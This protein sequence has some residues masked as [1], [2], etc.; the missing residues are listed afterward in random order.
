MSKPGETKA[1]RISDYFTTKSPTREHLVKPPSQQKK[2]AVERRGISGSKKDMNTSAKVFTKI[3]TLIHS[4]KKEQ[5]RIPSE[6]QKQI[7]HA[8]HSVKSALMK[9]ISFQTS[10]TVSKDK[11]RSKQR[12]ITNTTSSV[13]SKQI[14]GMNS[15]RK[16]LKSPNIVIKH[17]NDFRKHIESTQKVQDRLSP[18]SRIRSRIGL[19]TLETKSKDK[20]SVE[21][22]SRRINT[23]TSGSVV[24]TISPAGV[25]K[26][27]EYFEVKKGAHAA[28]HNQV[29]SFNANA[30]VTTINKVN[31]SP[32]AAK[33]LKFASNIRKIM[34]KVK[35]EQRTSSSNPKSTKAP[36]QTRAKPCPE[37]DG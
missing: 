2:A 25:K 7:D 30:T 5:R 17:V 33:D 6:E 19:N 20:S 18:K 10:K 12:P 31:S 35:K 34:S 15:E 32:S 16:V 26:N 27:P 37:S 28:N 23:D 36:S 3:Q 24:S 1:A 4:P 22:V 8:F 13:D 14:T 29:S 11:S 21:S 9:T